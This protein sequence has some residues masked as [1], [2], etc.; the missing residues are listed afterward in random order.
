MALLGYLQS[1]TTYFLRVQAQGAVI[2]NNQT[3]TIGGGAVSGNFTLTYKG[4]TTANIAYSSSLTA[5]TV[6][7][8]FQL[9]STVS[10]NCTVSGPN[11]GPY[12]FT[13]TGALALDTTAMTATNVSLTGGTPTIVVTQTQIYNTYTHD[14]AIKV[15]KPS[16]FADDQGVF[17]IEWDCAIV[18]D[19]G[20]GKA[21]T[22]TVTNLITAL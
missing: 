8:A 10:T 17:A 12:V 4:Q 1:G 20:W 13:F 22:V 14:M 11:G 21:Q 7:T 18:E 2:D 19:A 5:A 6:Q 16:A 15:G 3:L 9:L